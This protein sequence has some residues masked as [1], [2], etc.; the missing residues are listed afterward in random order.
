M[1]HAVPST[2]MHEISP[3]PKI[4]LMM[5][6]VHSSIIGTVEEQ[7]HLNETKYCGI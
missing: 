7:E 3:M 4:T 1:V 5:I 2:R 6:W